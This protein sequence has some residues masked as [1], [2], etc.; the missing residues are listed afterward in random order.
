MNKRLQNGCL[1]DIVVTNGGIGQQYL[2]ISVTVPYASLVQ[3]VAK[4]YGYYP[5]SSQ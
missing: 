1:G 3:V 2:E 5:W 4:I